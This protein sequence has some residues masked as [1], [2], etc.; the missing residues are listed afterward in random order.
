MSGWILEGLTALISGMSAVFMILIII[1]L[2]ISG[3]GHTAKFGEKKVK[4]IEPKTL[5][6]TPTLVD[7]GEE[8]RRIVAAITVALSQELGIRRDQLVIKKLR[9]LN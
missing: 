3:L 8:R 9:R 6:E 1:S 4:A 2:M 7:D 5:V